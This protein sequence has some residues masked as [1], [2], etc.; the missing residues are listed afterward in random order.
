MVPLQT[1]RIATGLLE[2]KS[3]LKRSGFLTR[4]SDGTGL[5]IQP[6]AGSQVIR[7]FVGC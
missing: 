1:S 3:F 4:W 6:V 5:R 2:T 7:E